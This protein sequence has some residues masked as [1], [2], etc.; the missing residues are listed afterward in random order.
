MKMAQDIYCSFLLSGHEFA[1]AVKSVQEVVN[2]PESYTRVPLSPDYLVGMFNLRG[3]I[4]PVVDL[5]AV[6]KI[7]SQSSSKDLK[8][9]AIVEYN[10]VL[11]GLVFD[12]T[13]EVFRAHGEEKSDFSYS[14]NKLS[15]I[16]GAFKLDEGRRIIQIIDP[17]ALFN[18]EHVPHQNGGRTNTD[19]L[20]KRSRGLRKQC[21]S[22]VTGPARC[23]LGIENIQEILKLE[24][25]KSS[26]LSVN[27][28]LGTIEIRG[29]L[30]P[31]IDFASLLGYR[32]P[33]RKL[34]LTN[35]NRRVLVLRFEKELFG[36]MVDSIESIVTYFSDDLLPFPVLGDQKRKLFTGCVSRENEADIVL[37][38]HA[39]IF[40]S[41][42]INEITH[43]H[44][45]IYQAKERAGTTKTQKGVTKTYITFHLECLY[46]VSINEIREIIDLPTTLLH[47]PGLPDYFQ[48][49]M[50]LRGDLVTIVNTRSMYGI[51]LNSEKSQA[52]KV[53]IFESAGGKYGLVVD[54]VD[55][56]LSMS[57]ENKMAIPEILFKSA[58][59]AMS[60]DVQEAVEVTIEGKQKKTVFILNVNAIAAR[61]GQPAAQAISSVA[62]S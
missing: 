55:A 22:F 8:K 49:V 47:P 54:A 28:Y 61:I 51:P 38:N 31:V 17:T 12:S 40:T 30:V 15:V 44:S 26:M 48:G 13:G 2:P 9:I 57:D 56:I 39:E 4:V 32:E 7:E 6:L 20:L 45:K 37:L 14:E 19:S 5:H 52:Q 21:I 46:A 59:A 53:L 50:N 23:A 25:L 42:E 29:N 24:S 27:H 11:I 62:A 60:A 3:T 41:H 36:L 18:L 1:L 58:K 10:Q 35:D 16:N 43:G 33:D 34:T